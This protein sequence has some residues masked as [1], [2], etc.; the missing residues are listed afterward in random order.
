MSR[1]S[2]I[3]KN[4]VALYGGSR[5]GELVLNLAS[6]YQ[7]YDAVIA[8]APS[9]VTLPT[10]FGWGAT[11]SWSFF[12]EEVPYLASANAEPGGEFFNE[13]SSMLED[14][15][16]VSRAAIPVERINGPILLLS[17]KGDEVWPS[18]L[19]CSKMVERLK[20]KHFSYQ[21]EH[22]PLEGSHAA[23]AQNSEYIFDFLEKHFVSK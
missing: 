11:S 4:K 19:M 18:T 5:G 20:S 8:I 14:E 6:R 17:A 15:Q 13:L 21:V 7:D 12:D 2:R 10:R 22:I 23:A 16:A 3:N 9:N 1:H